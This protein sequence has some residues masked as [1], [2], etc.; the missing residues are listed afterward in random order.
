MRNIY[1]VAAREYAENAKTKGFWIGVFL[2]PIIIIASI[3]IQGALERATPTRNFV[4]LDRSGDFEQHL[5]DGL[6]RLHDRDVM[7]AF[8]KYVREHSSMGGEAGFS[9]DMLESIPA[10]DTR[11][12]LESIGD[13]GASL[14]PAGGIDAALMQIE[15]FLD[16]EAPEFEE[17]RRRFRRVELPGDVPAD[18]DLADVAR[19]LKPYLRGKDKFDFEGDSIDLFAA[20]LIPA[21]IS[22]KVQRPGLGAVMSAISGGPPQGIQYWSANLADE[23]LRNEVRNLVNG[24]VRRREYVTEGMDVDKVQR[25]EKTRV[26]FASLNPKKEEGE[27]A[28][29]LADVIRQWA[30][31]GFVY[32]LWVAIFTISQM[33]LNNTIEEK[34]NRIIEVLLS[35][36]TPNELMLGKLFGIAAVGLTMI[37]AWIGSG[38]GVL[39]TRSGP[40]AEFATQLFAVLRHSGLLPAFVVYFIL[41]YLMYAGIFL[42]IGGVC[43]TL[44]E[45]QNMMGPVML[46]LI[47]PLFTMMFIPKDPNGTLATVMSWIPLYTPFVMM[48]RAAADPPMFEIVGTFVLLLVS[49]LLVLWLTGKIFRVGILRTG[50]APKLLELVRWVRS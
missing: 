49:T 43:N 10:P 4:F 44:K 17:P 29:S 33:L 25:I 48:N 13:G 42:A 24:E 36:V 35:S 7:K 23:E 15:P 45:A 8:G 3:F 18:A 34:S 37:G 50:Q 5:E 20:I 47:V 26:P 19:G 14:M 40:E 41:G 12:L 21:D 30:P 22:E 32:L 31:V 16:D 28:V 2:F 39:A 9:A 1:L 46:I 27:E 38:I 11:E 6:Q